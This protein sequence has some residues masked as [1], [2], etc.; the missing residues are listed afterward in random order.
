MLQ[1]TYVVREVSVTRP[2]LLTGDIRIM[3][4]VLATPGPLR[5]REHR[6]RGNSTNKKSRWIQRV[7]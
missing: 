5:L 4:F 7:S 2:L 3:I 6:G 1:G